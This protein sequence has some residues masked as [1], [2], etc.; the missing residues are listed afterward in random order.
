MS[1]SQER[2]EVIEPS[3]ERRRKVSHDTVTIESDGDDSDRSLPG[4]AASSSDEDS[5]DEDP[6]S[7]FWFSGKQPDGLHMNLTQLVCYFAACAG[8]ATKSSSF[9]TGRK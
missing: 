6:V 1:C 4:L 5:D 8:E 9:C 2:I 3:P 7:P